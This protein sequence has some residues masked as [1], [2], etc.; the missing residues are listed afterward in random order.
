MLASIL[1]NGKSENFS[2]RIMQ[3]EHKA[4]KSCVALRKPLTSEANWKKV[5]FTMENKHLDL[6]IKKGSE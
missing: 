5:A 1:L 6:W 3:R 4:F 2:T